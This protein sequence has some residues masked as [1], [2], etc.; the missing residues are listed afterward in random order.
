MELRCWRC[1]AVI[2]SSDRFCTQCRAGIGSGTS[3]S[4]GG[5]R[6]DLAAFKDLTPA[7]K[8]LA[9]LAVVALIGGLINYAMQHRETEKTIREAE[10]QLASIDPVLRD[11]LMQEKIGMTW[12]QAVKHDRGLV[13][14]TLG[15]NL[16][17]CAAYIGLFFWARRN[18]VVAASI[19]LALYV[20]V[21]ILNLAFDHKTLLQGVP[22]KI[23]FIA[24]LVAAIGTAQ[25]ER[26]RAAAAAAAAV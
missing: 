25:R 2:A 17:L 12:A 10:Q 1:A 22:L 6:L 20:G 18:A 26:Q 14:L 4:T 8:Y 15:F 11:Q 3:L 23:V 13:D 21:I 7:R 9:M 16:G 19:A 24:G 5:P